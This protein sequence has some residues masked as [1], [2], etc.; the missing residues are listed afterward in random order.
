MK[1]LLLISV[2]GVLLASST[3]AVSY[4]IVYVRAPRAGDNTYTQWAEVYSP[5]GAEPGSDLILLHPDGSEE[6]LVAAG[7][8]AVADPCVSFDA[9]WIYYS[10]FPDLSGGNWVGNGPPLSG[11]DIYK[12]NVA[13]RQIVQLT[14]GEYTPNTSVRTSPLPYGIYN[15]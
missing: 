13:T 2:V 1:Q 8:G 9:Q 10:Y 4:D 14:H 7:K 12:I 15:M 6:V 5:M 3:A 11:A